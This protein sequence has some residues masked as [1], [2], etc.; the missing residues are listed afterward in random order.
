M[1]LNLIKRAIKGLTIFQAP[2]LVSP[3]VR[4]LYSVQHSQN[5]FKT[6]QLGSKA[7]AHNGLEVRAWVQ[8]GQ[9]RRW[10]QQQ[11]EFWDVTQ[12]LPLPVLPCR[13][14]P[15]PL[16]FCASSTPLPVSGGLEC[17]E[18][19]ACELSGHQVWG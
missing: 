19:R 3:F 14:P 9:G 11:D 12:E 8:P 5:T 10:G 13:F 17:C 1:S 18:T 16:L 6:R 2:V 7:P 4:D 15:V